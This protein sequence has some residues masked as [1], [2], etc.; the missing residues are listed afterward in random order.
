MKLFNSYMTEFKINLFIL[1]LEPS[2]C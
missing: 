2:V 1:L